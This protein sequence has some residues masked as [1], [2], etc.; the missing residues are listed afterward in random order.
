M[1]AGELKHRIELYTVTT[2]DDGEGGYT[3]TETLTATRYAKVTQLSM[4]ESLRTGQ[5]VGESNYKITYRKAPA[6]TLDKTTLIKWNGKRM[7]ITA[8]VSDDY[9]FYVNCSEAVV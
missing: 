6:E 4:S 8:V 9:W 5:V 7:N 1:K 2:T 3:S